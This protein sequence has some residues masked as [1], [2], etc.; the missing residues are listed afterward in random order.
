MRFAIVIEK[1]EG[2][3]SAYV[4]DLLGYVATGTT[5]EAAKTQSAKPLNFILRGCVKMGWSSH[6]RQAGLV[7]SRWR[8][9]ICSLHLIQRP[10][11]F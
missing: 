6:N 7:M 2:N 11:Q 1:A 4:T 5:V 9:S 10:A 8:R 3:F